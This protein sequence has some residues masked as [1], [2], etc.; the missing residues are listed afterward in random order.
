[1][2]AI[3]FIGGDW[4][5]RADLA[6]RAANLSAEEAHAAEDLALYTVNTAS[7]YREK[8]LP[9][10]AWCAGRI[11][12]KLPYTLGPWQ[13]LADAGDSAYRAELGDSPLRR[14]PSW[15]QDAV[16]DAAAVLIAR[17]Y[18]EEI[19]EALESAS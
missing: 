12:R 18:V 8:A 1:M 19:A 9:T 6:G 13:R 17:N 3:T 11:A 16:R 10:I 4:R 7:L 14:V 2:Q 5:V 15:R